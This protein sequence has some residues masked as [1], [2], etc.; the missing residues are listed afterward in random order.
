MITKI[1]AALLFLGGL[2]A[3]PVLAQDHYAQWQN[4]INALLAADVA[5]P[6]P[7]NGVVFAGSS[8]IRMWAATLAGDFPG[9][10]VVDRGFGGSVISDSTFYAHRLIIPL[11][12]RLIVF[13]AGDNDISQGRTPD[14]TADDFKAFVARVRRDLPKVAVAFIA[15]KPSVARWAQWPSMQGANE[16]IAHWTKTQKDIAFIDIAPRM[17]DANGK[18]RPELLKADG[19]HMTA[20]GYAIWVDAVRPVLAKYGFAGK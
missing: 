12:P 4:E 9:V 18:P 2:V 15:I 19:L 1:A 14:Q 11:H 7:Q 13:Y 17:L 3:G 10:P 20:A 6:P 8:S 5:N 16:R